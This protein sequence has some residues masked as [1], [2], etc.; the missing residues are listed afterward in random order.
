MIAWMVVVLALAGFS[1]VGSDAALSPSSLG[2]GVTVTP[3][4]G[5]ESAQSRWDVGAGAISLQR[6]GVL[7]AFTADSYSG[8]VQQLLDDQSSDA[9]R[10]FGSF[11]SLR[12]A[13]ATIAGDVP[14]LKLLFSGSATD[15]GDLEG[16]LVAAVIGRTG[17]VMLAM[18]PAGQ[19]ARAQADLDAMLAGLVVP[20]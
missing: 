9:R 18:A 5:W 16:E 17:V 19:M 7:V 3:A 15:S 6:A 10:R 12:P 1:G 14:A 2:Q 4:V 8:S 11:R 20:R 13:P